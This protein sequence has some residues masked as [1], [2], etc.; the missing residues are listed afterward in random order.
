MPGA[1]TPQGM[2]GLTTATGEG[3]DFLFIAAV[4]GHHEGVLKVSG[5]IQTKGS[6]PEVKVLARQILAIHQAELTILEPLAIG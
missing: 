4:I 6:D 3:F 1:S 2:F 5:G